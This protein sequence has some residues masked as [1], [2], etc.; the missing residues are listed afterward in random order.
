LGANLKWLEPP[1][2][3]CNAARSCALS[4]ARHGLRQTCG[5]LWDESWPEAQRLKKKLSEYM[6]S[7]DWF[8]ANEPE[9]STV[10][11]V[12]EN[13]GE[14]MLWFASDYLS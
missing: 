14:D 4:L 10:R 8:Y 7:G 3:Q 11:Y 5:G 2:P 1:G 9:A 13:I 12:I 6:T